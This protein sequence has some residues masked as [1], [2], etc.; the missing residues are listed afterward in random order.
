MKTKNLFLT[1][2]MMIFTITV[3]IAQTNADSGNWM[4]SFTTTEY[5][6]MTVTCLM[7][8]AIWVLGRTIKTLSDQLR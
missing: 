4:N 5:L 7:A 6:L 2:M 3:S 1:V 8:V